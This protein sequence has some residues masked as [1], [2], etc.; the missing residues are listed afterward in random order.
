MG[1]VDLP[2]LIVEQA[3][4]PL[5]KPDSMTPFKNSTTPPAAETDDSTRR[6]VSIANRADAPRAIS[7][8]LVHQFWI[9]LQVAASKNAA[10]APAI[11]AARA[12]FTSLETRPEATPT[13][14]TSIAAATSMLHP[15]VEVIRVVDLPMLLPRECTGSVVGASSRPSGA[16]LARA[17]RMA[18]MVIFLTMFAVKT[19]I[20]W[21]D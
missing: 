11:Q 21:M 8:V 20:Q 2:A 13:A 3:Q 10:P 6:A 7:V 19:I 16:A 5:L 4:A 14:H 12:A 18:T 17:A 15:S 1:K 9:S